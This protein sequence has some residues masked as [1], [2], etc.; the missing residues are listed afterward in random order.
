MNQFAAMCSMLSLTMPVHDPFA[1][2]PWVPNWLICADCH[3]EELVKDKAVFDRIEVDL[4]YRCPK[5]H[6]AKL[7]WQRI[8]DRKAP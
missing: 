7:F 3:R 8:T 6:S 2:T 5:C 4:N 1:P